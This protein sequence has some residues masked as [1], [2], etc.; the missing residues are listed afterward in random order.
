MK[1]PMLKTS[2]LLAAVSIFGTGCADL[3]PLQNAGILGVA[4]GTAAGGIARAS[5]ASTGESVA[6]GAATGAVVAAVTYI[7]AKHQATERQHRIAEERA[8]R[9]YDR[10]PAERKKKARKTRYIAVDTEKNEQT[11]AGAKKSVMIWDTQSQEVV[12]NNV[13]DVKSPPPVGSTA[14]FD[15]YS[16]EYVGSGS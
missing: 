16:A 3:T 7:I 8:Q 2:S 11:S 13:Y 14:Q 6:I 4:G 1:I 12:G 15:T 5:G 10:M 9:A